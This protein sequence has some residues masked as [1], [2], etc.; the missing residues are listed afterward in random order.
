MTELSIEQIDEKIQLVNKLTLIMK[1]LIAGQ[2]M[3]NDISIII[4]VLKNSNEGHYSFSGEL[5]IISQG[6]VKF[7]QKY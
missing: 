6:H 1:E 7:R 2:Y 4:E 3:K 5:S